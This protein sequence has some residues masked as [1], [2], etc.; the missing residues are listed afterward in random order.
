MLEVRVDQADLLTFILAEGAKVAAVALVVL[1]RAYS[2]WEQRQRQVAR[3]VGIA[4]ET[5]ERAVKGAL[6][7]KARRHR[8]SREKQARVDLAVGE[9]ES[10]MNP[11]PPSP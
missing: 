3:L 7:G 8:E 2:T 1:A 9:Q 10:G 11:L 6:E 4:P 5:E